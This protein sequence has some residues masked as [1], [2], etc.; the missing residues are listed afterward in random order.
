MEVGEKNDYVTENTDRSGQKTRL[1]Y[2]QTRTAVGKKQNYV[3]E[4][5]GRSGQT[6]RLCYRKNTDRSGQKTRLCYRKTRTERVE[7]PSRRAGE[8]RSGRVSPRGG[9]R[10]TDAGS[11]AG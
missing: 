10:K 8:T 11:R 6:T 5:H 4:K 7:I 1:C 9:A 3:T 2:R